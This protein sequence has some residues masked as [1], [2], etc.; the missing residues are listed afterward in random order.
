VTDPSEAAPA[1]T[2]AIDIGG[3]KVACAD[4]IGPACLGRSQIA[5]P[6]TGR[7]ADLVAAIASEVRR[8]GGSRQ[9]RVGV[10]TTG[11]VR[12]GRPT[13]LN[14]STLPIENDFPL[15]GTLEAKGRPA[16]VLNDA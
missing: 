3:T 7:G 13:A 12:E 4:V 5:T 11:L 14:P 2:L 8:R 15:A 1:P 10:A 9:G 6:R 16:V